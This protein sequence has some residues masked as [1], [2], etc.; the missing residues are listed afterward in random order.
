VHLDVRV[1]LEPVEEREEC[2]RV[3][4]LGAGRAA[5]EGLRHGPRVDARPGRYV[6]FA[7]G[8]YLHATGSD[9]S[10]WDGYTRAN[11]MAA[12]DRGWLV[13]GDT[14]RPNTQ[15]TVKVRCTDRLG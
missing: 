9:V 11:L 3:D 14:F 13:V 7:G 1:S 5:G 4:V 12:D 6:A 2:R 15:L 10:T 8:G